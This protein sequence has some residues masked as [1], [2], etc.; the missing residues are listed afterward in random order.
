[1]ATAHHIESL[2]EIHYRAM[3]ELGGGI[4]RAF[5]DA[6]IHGIPP[7]V[8]F[9]SPNTGYTLSIRASQMSA[10]AVRTEIRKSDELYVIV[11]GG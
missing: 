1:M 10:D 7:I 5:C 3:V 4:F 6:E 2:K 9:D 8:V 11:H